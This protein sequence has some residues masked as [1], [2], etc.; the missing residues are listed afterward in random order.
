SGHG[1]DGFL[2]FQDAEEISNVELADAFEQMWQKQRYHEVLFIVDTCQ[3]VSLYQ[4]FYS[5]N[6]MAIGSSQVGE[7]SLS[8]HM[9]SSIGVFVI[10]RYTY[11]LLDFLENIHPSTRKTMTDLFQV[12]PPRD[13]ISTPGWRTDLFTRDPGSVL[14]TDFFGSVRNVELT[15]ETVA[16]PRQTRITFSDFRA[17]DPDYVVSLHPP[18]KAPRVE[19]CWICVRVG[20]R[21]EWHPPNAFIL[22]FWAL[23]LLVFFK[24]Y[25]AKHLPFIF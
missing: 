15:M 19:N 16:L 20:K 13:C 11:H 6:V 25:G 4:R 9:D 21:R 1:G 7:D 10:D 23:V 24:A 5:P 17:G 22:S 18:L 3:A 12:C 2:K 8:H 14:I